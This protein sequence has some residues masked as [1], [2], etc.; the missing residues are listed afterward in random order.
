MSKLAVLLQKDAR[1]IYRDGFL[2]YMCA[3]APLLALGAR[4]GV[5]WIPVENLDLYVAP[6]VVMLG[7]SLIAIVAGFGLIEENEHRTLLLLRVVPLSP[8]AHLTYLVTT[9]GALAFLLGLAAALSF[10]R[11]PADLTSFLLMTAVGSLVAPLG[12]L[13]L[14]LVAADKIEGMALAKIL[15]ALSFLPALVFVIPPP[16][17]L[18]LVWCPYYWVYLGLLRAYAGEGQ[19]P[20]LAAGWPGYPEWAYPLAATVLCIAAITLLARIQRARVG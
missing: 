16:W 14:G 10:G 12:T 8:Q 15:S 18:L 3:Y 20:A 9:T 17:Q 11:P 1:G 7:A 6:W 2:L 19:L 4:A 13:L 5:P